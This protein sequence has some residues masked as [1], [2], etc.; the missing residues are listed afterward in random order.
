M[1]ARQPASSSRDKGG[2]LSFVQIASAIASRV[3]ALT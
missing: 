1:A 3:L 2:I